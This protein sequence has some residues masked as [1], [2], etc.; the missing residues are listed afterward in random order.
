MFD[1]EL[2]RSHFFVT[3][4]SLDENDVKSRMGHVVSNEGSFTQEKKVCT[5]CWQIQVVMWE[6]YKLL[7]RIHTRSLVLIF[8][9]DFVTLTKLHLP[10]RVCKPGSILHVGKL[11]WRCLNKSTC[12]LPTRFGWWKSFLVTFTW[13]W[14]CHWVNAVLQ[15]L[16]CVLQPVLQRSNHT[17]AI[18]STNLQTLVRCWQTPPTCSCKR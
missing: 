8:Q 17:I 9:H 18:A 16:I 2:R 1:S 4:P 11:F 5:S 14:N 15:T 3:W 6:R 7:L 12:K 10:T 13:A